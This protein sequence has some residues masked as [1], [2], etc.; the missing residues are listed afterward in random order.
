M[1]KYI[2]PFLYLELPLS[3]IPFESA[4]SRR[5]RLAPGDGAHSTCYV[6]GSGTGALESSHASN[7]PPKHML[8]SPFLP[9]IFTE[10]QSGEVTCPRSK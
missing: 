7:H 9:R 6:L 10:G 2:K 5:V 3:V 1:L 4:V 8:L